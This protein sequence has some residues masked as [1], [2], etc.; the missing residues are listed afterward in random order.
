MDDSTLPTGSLEPGNDAVRGGGLRGSHEKMPE[1]IGAYR[2]REV[3]GEGGFGVVYLAEQSEPVKRRVAVKV[4]KAGMDSKAVLARF[5]AER[6]AL[7]VMDHPG[8]A[9][10]FDGGTTESGLAYFAMELVRGESITAFCD[11]H[12]LSIRQRL[13]LFQQV[14]GAVQHAHM[15]GVIHRDLKP[16]NILVR[17]QGDDAQAKVIDFG[18]AKALHQKLS[19]ATVYTEQGQLIGTPAYMSPEQAEMSAQDIDTRSDVYSLGVVLYE[20]LSGELPFSKETLRE[21]GVGE[22]QRII[23]DVEPAKPSTKVSTEVEHAREIAERRRTESRTLAGVLKRDLDWVVMRCLEKDRSRRY[24]TA[25]ALAMELERYLKDEPVLAGPPSVGYR[26]GKFV[27][28]NRAGVIAAVVGLTLLV[29][30]FAGTGYGLVEADSAAQR[31]E[32]RAEELEAVLLAVDEMLLSIGSGRGGINITVKEMMDS[33]SGSLE[34]LE[35]EYPR[36]AARMRQ[37]L[38]IGYSSID[39]FEVGWMHARI[40]SELLCGEEG[41]GSAQD[42]YVSRMLAMRIMRRFGMWRMEH[43]DYQ[44]GQPIFMEALGL[45]QALVEEA[46]E[47]K[48]LENLLPY[49]WYQVG[50]SYAG[51]ARDEDSLAAYRNAAE[52][53][54]GSESEELSLAMNE[55]LGTSRGVR[56]EAASRIA[57]A[58]VDLDLYEEGV[59]EYKRVL[60]LVR[61]RYGV[62]SREFADQLRYTDYAYA[63]AGEAELALACLYGAARL[64]RTMR[65][66]SDEFF[67]KCYGGT[68]NRLRELGRVDDAVWM[69]AETLSRN[70]F[71]HAPD[72][73]HTVRGHQRLV[74]WTK[75][76]DLADVFEPVFRAWDA[77][78]YEGVREE[79]QA[80]ILAR[81]GE[82]GVDAIMREV[83]EGVALESIMPL[84]W[85]AEIPK[86]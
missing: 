5:E 16:S 3:L 64:G 74:S 56:I 36:A 1:W 18:V 26:V 55:I 14:C 29:G 25:N 66:E 2:V 11:K 82:E 61:E 32:E 31:A 59:A 34:E 62:R 47:S 19:D 84:E 50:R 71:S 80:L 27:K 37:T 40:A 20:L 75:G 22:I 39:E 77:G 44:Q 85:W 17:Y 9:Q 73:M 76:G 15:K 45:A 58:V 41:G 4:I 10:I 33:Q 79:I 21:A 12:K 65:A 7:A 8:I 51:V 30:G 63:H 60:G 54:A 72:N 6:Q 52:F 53:V 46:K 48:E 67:T 35:Q 81:F 70:L 57:Q 68:T 24:E 23:R 38:A 43:G 28:R 78:E 69:Q 42:C 86:E 83:T 49:A 13:E